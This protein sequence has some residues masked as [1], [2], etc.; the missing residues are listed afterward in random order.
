MT[1]RLPLPV[2]RAA[3]F[4]PSSTSPELAV[5][6]PTY[7][8][9]GNIGPML[10]ALRA[11]LHGVDFEVIFVDDDSPDGTIDLVRAAADCDQRVRGIRRIRRRGLAGAVIE[12]ALSTSAQ[13]VAVIDCDGQHDE[14]LLPDM[15]KA[16]REGAD[17][18]IGSRF[19][20][21]GSAREGLSATRET[22]SRL[23]I[24]MA[25]RVLGVG[26]SDP[27]S[28]FFM[29]RRRTF[30]QIAPKLSA[31]GFKLL[32]DILVSAKPQTL[33]IREF[34]YEFRARKSGQSK[35]GTTVIADFIGLLLS[36]ATGDAVSP[37]FLMFSCVGISGLI[38][39]MI[40]LKTG[41]T[42]GLPFD[43][44]QVLAAYIAMLSNFVLNNMLTYADVRLRGW[45]AVRGFVSFA[46]VCSVGTLANV[47]VARLIY[48]EDPNW[49]L[50]GTAGA[51]MAAVF[52]F[53]TTSVLTWRKT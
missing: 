19:A 34:S 40:S 44:A 29:M 22:A 47:G 7:C 12:G 5:I 53:A 41:L 37:R 38:V 9:A 30:E 39:H 23:A 11:A 8:E 28:G 17:I 46:L 32:L 18:T 50:A 52:N 48:A 31:V 26:L 42:A 27:M 3:A 10:Q 21:N 33:G 4:R 15:L 25:D 35:L 36:K 43:H 24:R 20:G 51:L 13:Y 2:D 14:G 16:L 49:F 45:A 6:V 1:I